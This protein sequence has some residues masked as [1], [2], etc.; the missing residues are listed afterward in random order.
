M[1]NQTSQTERTPSPTMTRPP[2]LNRSVLPEIGCW[3]STRQRP[4]PQTAS[5]V[6]LQAEFPCLDSYLEHVPNRLRRGIHGCPPNG[7]AAQRDNAHSV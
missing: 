4:L 7:V 5:T 2:L 3:Q 6:G 1:T